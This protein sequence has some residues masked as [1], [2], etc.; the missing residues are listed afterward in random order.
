MSQQKIDDFYAYIQ[1][2]DYLKDHQGEIAGRNG[3]RAGWINQIDLS[4]SQEIPGIFKGNKG[5]VKLDVYNFTNLLNKHWG[6]EHRVDFP[7]GRYLA[8]YYGVDPVTGKYIYDISTANY[9]GAN[10]GYSPKAIP[11]YANSGD[12]LAQRWSVLLTVKYTF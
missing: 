4:F 5:I 1:K 12:D 8:D 6:I 2:N 11:T 3:D 10:G 9:T 7:G